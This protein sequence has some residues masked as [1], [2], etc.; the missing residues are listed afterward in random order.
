VAF[1]GELQ[2]HYQS[3]SAI[4]INDTVRLQATLCM[5]CSAP[6]D[7]VASAPIAEPTAGELEM[8]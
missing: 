2:P 1:L 3:S 6:V 7:F 5:C 4:T 8:F